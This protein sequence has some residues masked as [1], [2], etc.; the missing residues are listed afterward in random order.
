MRKLRLKEIK[1]REEGGWL[2]N[3]SYNL[4]D[5]LIYHIISQLFTVLVY[6]YV[7]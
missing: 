4:S 7:I 2:A 1:M 6:I 5:S 3:L